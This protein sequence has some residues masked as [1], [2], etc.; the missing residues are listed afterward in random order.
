MAAIE[1]FAPNLVFNLDKRRHRRDSSLYSTGYVGAT[2][3]AVPFV[4]GLRVCRGRRVRLSICILL[5]QNLHGIK[6]SI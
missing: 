5:A 1:R 2:K 6:H 4:D 3:F